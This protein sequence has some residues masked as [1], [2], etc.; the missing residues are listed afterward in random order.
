MIPENIS[1]KKGVIERCQCLFLLEKE[2]CQSVLSSLKLVRGFNQFLERETCS[3]A[4]SKLSLN[5]S[6][7]ALFEVGIIKCET[8][9]SSY[10]ILTLHISFA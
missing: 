8:H 5:S 6:P 2:G 10:Y 4:V 3:F 9:L 7:S 1:L